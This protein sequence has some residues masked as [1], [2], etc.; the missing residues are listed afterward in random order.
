MNIDKFKQDHV[1]IFRNITDLRNLI[2]G[3]ISQNSGEITQKIISISSMIKLHLAAEDRTLYPMLL[4]SNNA[5]I[6]KAGKN[7]QAEMDGIAVAYM[8]FSR[9]W[10]LDSRIAN[11]PEEFREEA[12]NVFRNLHQRITHENKVLYPLAERA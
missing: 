10:N 4:N 11:N 7:F 2:R 3:G 12:N 6:A 5:E 1:S 8:E 9:K